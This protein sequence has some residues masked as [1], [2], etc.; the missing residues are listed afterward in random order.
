MPEITQLNVFFVAAVVLALTPGPG[1]FYVLARSIKGGRREGVLSTAGT[2]VGGLFHVMAAALGVSAI[3]TTSAVAFGVVKYAGAAYLIY[4]G[5]RTLLH[6][7]ATPKAMADPIIVRKTG[8]FKEGVVTE[9][10]N[11][12]TALFF[13]AFIPQ[14]INP[15]GFVFAQFLLLGCISVLLNSSADIAVA[16]IAGPL[17]Y[18]MMRNKK[19]QQGQ[20]YGSGLSFV[21]LGTYVAITDN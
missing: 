7:P 16:F 19:L 1:I 10:L 17:G 9:A 21:A 14:F 8:A 11:P 18:K 12:K 5:L 3:L 20:R 15:A 13:L 6:Q 4:L 2:T